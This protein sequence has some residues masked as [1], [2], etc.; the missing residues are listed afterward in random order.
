MSEN[1]AAIEGVADRV[2]NFSVQSNTDICGKRRGPPS[3]IQNT[4]KKDKKWIP[5]HLERAF[6]ALRET[7]EKTTRYQSHLDF[8]GCYLKE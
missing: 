7:T 2:N 4:A 5:P 3:D 1:D 8:L 6:K